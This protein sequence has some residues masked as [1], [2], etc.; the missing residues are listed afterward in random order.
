[1]PKNC[2]PRL[3]QHFPG[4]DIPI[5][6]WAEVERRFRTWPGLLRALTRAV[7][8]AENPGKDYDWIGEAVRA[9]EATKT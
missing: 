7:E 4:A 3:P 6:S 8:A 9:I 5:P 1:M 2:K